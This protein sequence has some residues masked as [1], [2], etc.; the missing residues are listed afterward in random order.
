MTPQFQL[1]VTFY[2]L[3]TLAHP[4]TELFIMVQTG[5]VKDNLP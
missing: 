3:Q 5:Q 1:Q 2:K 4:F